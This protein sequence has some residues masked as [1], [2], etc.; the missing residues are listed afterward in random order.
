MVT[1]TSGFNRD[2][3]EFVFE[4]GGFFFPSLRLKR[5]IAQVFLLLFMLHSFSMSWNAMFLILLS[6]YCVIH[7]IINSLHNITL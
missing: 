2:T 4:E 1:L 5:L 7:F 6:L 3:S